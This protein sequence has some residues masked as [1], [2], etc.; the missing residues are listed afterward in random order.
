MHVC[1]NCGESNPVANRYCLKCGAELPDPTTVNHG[2]VTSSDGEN[3]SQRADDAVI[4]QFDTST[5]RFP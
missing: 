1:E 4:E 3:M 2:A 5:L